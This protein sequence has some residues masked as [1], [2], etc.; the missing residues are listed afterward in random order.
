MPG[1]DPLAEVLADAAEPAPAAAKP[2]VDLTARL[3]ALSR[4]KRE[5]TIAARAAELKATEAQT[6]LADLDSAL[7]AARKDPKKVKDLL[8]RVGLDFRQ[9]VDVYAEDDS[10]ATPETLAAKTLADTKAAVDELKAERAKDAA[11]AQAKA[12][13][14]QRVETLAGISQTIAKAADKYEICARLGDEAANDVFT[15]VTDAWQRAGRPQ[16]DPGEFEDAV[17]AAIETQELRY[18]ERGKKL[19]KTAKG[20]AAATAAGAAPT[21]RTSKKTG[22]PAGLVREDHGELSDKDKAIIEGLVDKSAPAETSQRTKPRTISSSL[23]GSAPPRTVATGEM[24]P[25]EAFRSLFPQ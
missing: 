17:A 1:T 23:G 11:A 24:D 6:K 15:I 7:D 2:K 12:V 20:A 16:L 14:A 9:V 18:E 19:A 10:V 4:G 13:E 3:A 25:R 8:A 22:L 21:A 5:A